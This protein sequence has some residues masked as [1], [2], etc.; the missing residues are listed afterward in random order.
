MDEELNKHH[1]HTE[2]AMRSADILRLVIPQISKHKLAA[3][4]INY[5]VW[6]EYYLATNVQLKQAIDTNIENGIAF[7]NEL[8][9]SFFDSYIAD[10]NTDAVKQAQEEVLRII[11]CLSETAN[12]TDSNASD[13]HQSLQIYADQLES[14]TASQELPKILSNLVAETQSMQLSLQTMRNNMDDSQRE[15]NE[16]RCKLDQVTAEALTD[17]LTG[18]ANRKGFSIAFEK[19]LELN[20]AASSCIS[21]LMVDIDH[22]K[23]VNDTHGHLVGDKVIKYVADT[24]TKL[25]QDQ[26]TASRFGGEEY[27]VL[28]PNTSL[29]DAQDIA[30]TIRNKIEIAKLRRSNTQE[31]IGQITVSIGIGCLQA[32][33]TLDSLID[34]ADTAL[35]LSKQNG[36]NRVTVDHSKNKKAV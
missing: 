3:T 32:N 7:S 26:D 20:K 28:L 23:K 2:S 19:T 22:F 21:L 33:E 15:I 36:R 14:S 16:L 30:E 25:K 29:N 31:P 1:R 27:A 10:P 35:Y 18:L 17:P 34:R 4:P 9:K 8:M 6:Y 24:L 11:A 5:T 12:A 13:Y